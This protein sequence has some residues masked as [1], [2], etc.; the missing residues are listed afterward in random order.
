MDTGI[1]NLLKLVWQEGFETSNSCQDARGKV[2]IQ[3]THL[4][5]FQQIVNDAAT[6]G[7]D[8]FDFVLESQSELLF[9]MSRSDVCPTST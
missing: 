4:K 9:E 5:D 8:L 3:F 2:W 1:V 7:R 6:F